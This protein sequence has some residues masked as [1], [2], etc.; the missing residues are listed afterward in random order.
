MPDPKAARPGEV[1]ATHVQVQFAI[2][3]PVRADSMVD[4]LLD[5]RLV[6]CGQR[7]GPVVSRYRWQGVLERAEE[8]LVLLKTRAELAPAV[9][10]AVV[11][12]HPYETP[13]VVVLDLAGGAPGY[14]AWIDSVTEAAG[15]IGP[16]PDTQTEER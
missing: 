9:I 3:D 12:A 15:T 13:E 11:E 4:Q 7:A 2:D 1:V 10:R 14:L 8:W 6:A 16:T 5:D